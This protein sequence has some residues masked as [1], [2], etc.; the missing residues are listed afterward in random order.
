LEIEMSHCHRK[1]R[2]SCHGDGHPGPIKQVVRG[3]SR[4][5][6]VKRGFVIAGFVLGFVFVPLLTLLVFLAAL[7]WVNHPENVEDTLDRLLRKVQRAIRGTKSRPAYADGGIGE[8]AI[9]GD[10]DVDLAKLRRRFEDLERRAETMEE[11][12]AS[13]EHTLNREFRRMRDE[14]K[15]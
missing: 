3:L 12:V 10:D 6:G 2:P 9:D 5:F 7:Y 15:S 8:V 11:Y 13:E 14:E 1:R 4:R